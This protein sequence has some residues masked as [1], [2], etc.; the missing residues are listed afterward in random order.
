M[1]RRF[2]FHVFA[3]GPGSGDT[4][5]SLQSPA[6]TEMPLSVPLGAPAPTPVRLPPSSHSHV[7]A[8]SSSTAV[9]LAPRHH[10]GVHSDG[11]CDE[12]DD[13]ALSSDDERVLGSRDFV[14]GTGKRSPTDHASCSVFTLSARKTNRGPLQRLALGA[15]ILTVNNQD[16]VAFSGSIVANKP[17]SAR[18]LLPK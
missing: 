16:I 15:T 5:L 10:E 11:S 1:L 12:V 14:M 6:T 18:P 9:P 13:G 3:D 4:R 2:S 8:P 7:P 17:S